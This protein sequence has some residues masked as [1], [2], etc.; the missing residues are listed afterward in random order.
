MFG[1]FKPKMKKIITVPGAKILLHEEIAPAS[2]IIIG[3]MMSF[4]ATSEMIEQTEYYQDMLDA[5]RKKI[6]ETEEENDS[7]S[8]RDSFKVSVYEYQQKEDGLSHE[9]YVK[10][11]NDYFN[12]NIAQFT[13][14]KGISLVVSD[15]ELFDMVKAFDELKY[16][17]IYVATDLAGRAMK[18]FKK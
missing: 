4:H 6:E 7:N 14:G 13:N 1:L 2:E 5:A 12:E 8:E 10:H 11:I 16:D 15:A 9:E 18:K 3:S 17:A